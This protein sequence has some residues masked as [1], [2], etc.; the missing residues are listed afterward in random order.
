[1]CGLIPA[2][3]AL[4]VCRVLMGVGYSAA[5]TA[6][7][8][9]STD[10]IPAS[11]LTEGVG[12][13]GAVVPVMSFFGPAVGRIL[14]S[15]LG[16]AK[17]LYGLSAIMLI[18]IFTLICFSIPDL[19]PVPKKTASGE[20]QPLLERASIA[21]SVLLMCVAGAQTSMVS[22]L[23]LYAQK[24]NIDKTLYL[25]IP[26][27]IGVFTIRILTTILKKKLPD[28]K[29][30]IASFGVCVLTL[31]ILPKSNNAFL[32]AIFGLCY[33]FAQG[34]LQP[35]F[36]TQALSA[37]PLGHK[38]TATVTYYIF[39][40]IGTV[41]LGMSWGY[42]AQYISY[43]AVFLVAACVNIAAFCGWLLLCLKN[44]QPEQE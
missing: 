40:D 14:V 24:Y 44:G 37:A 13:F 32:Y 31:L 8:T 30:V 38:S 1:A 9:A 29:S 34:V 35:C 5:T 7:N 12:Y 25:Y 28:N 21:P 41:V 17:M 2:I 36:I 43:Y 4:A 10:V 20:K 23:P 26:A 11:R 16:V 42:I 15:R 33:G 18:P 19:K 27:G 6:N 3:L 22:F 39:N